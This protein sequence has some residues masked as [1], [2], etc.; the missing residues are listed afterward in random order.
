MIYAKL[1]FQLIYS[2]IDTLCVRKENSSGTYIIFVYLQVLT[3]RTLPFAK[4]RKNPISYTQWGFDWKQANSLKKCLE[5]SSVTCGMHTADSCSGCPQGNG[6]AWC[7]KDC[8]WDW[9]GKGSIRAGD[10]NYVATLSYC[11]DKIVGHAVS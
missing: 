3:I 11:G 4:I 7:N 8:V 5:G 9:K 6:P 2:Y 10:K 1:H